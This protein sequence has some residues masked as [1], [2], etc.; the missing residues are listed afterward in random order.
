MIISL[1]SCGQPIQ[2]ERKDTFEKFTSDPYYVRSVKLYIKM[3]IFAVKSLFKQ[4]SPYLKSDQF[5]EL[6]QILWDKLPW[7]LQILGLYNEVIIS[8]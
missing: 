8:L 3:Y 2:R 7:N 6:Q 1:A 5:S 4:F